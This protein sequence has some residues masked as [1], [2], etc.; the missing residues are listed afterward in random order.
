MSFLFLI[1][2][3]NDNPIFRLDSSQRADTARHL[4][5]FI[6]HSSLDVID[7]IV[8]KK[9]DMYFRSVDRFGDSTISAFITASSK[10]LKQQ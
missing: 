9:S 4:Q 6:I 10:F 3:K 2:G 7:E 1:V 5:E 8:W